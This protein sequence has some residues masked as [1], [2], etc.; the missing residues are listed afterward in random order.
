MRS[1]VSC[2]SVATSSSYGGSCGSLLGSSSFQVGRGRDPSAEM[3]LFSHTRKP[4]SNYRRPS[5]LGL[6]QNALN[7]KSEAKLQFKPLPSSRSHIVAKIPDHLRPEGN[8]QKDTE[9]K[10]SY[11]NLAPNRPVIHKIPDTLR[12]PE[13]RM[14]AKSETN[15]AFEDKKPH[16]PVIHKLRDHDE[17]VLPNRLNRQ[18]GNSEYRK[19][20]QAMKGDRLPPT[21]LQNF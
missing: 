9:I 4:R 14:S 17:S 11:K 21:W 20:Y 5:S 15:L 19:H 18:D 7:A 3:E 8:F 13:G 16:R 10:A 2:A 6:S 12:Q 1:S